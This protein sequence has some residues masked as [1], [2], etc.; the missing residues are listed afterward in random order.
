MSKSMTRRKFLST[1]AAGLAGSAVLTS[2]P[3]SSYA[4][5]LGAND[6]I[7]MAVIG[8]RGRGGSHI[9]NFA[10]MK[11]VRLKYLVDV[12]ANLF[13]ARLKEVEEKSGYRPKTEMDMRKVYDDKEIDAVGYRHNQSLACLVNHLGGS[14]R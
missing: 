4:R 11:N 3:A 7:N 1:G 2:I 14:G 8:I 6:T 12:D 13:E 10:G 5:I 9:E